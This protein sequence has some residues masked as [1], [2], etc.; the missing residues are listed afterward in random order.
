[1]GT[2]SP[3]TLA[4]SL[5]SD[6]PFPPL[7][8]FRGATSESANLASLLDCPCEGHESTEETEE[9]KWIEESEVDEMIYDAV[10]DFEELQDIYFDSDADFLPYGE[11]TDQ[12]GSDHDSD[13]DS[14]E[15][16][17]MLDR[18]RLFR[19]CKN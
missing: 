4:S 14:E 17:G 6:N 5:L 13:A 2:P 10:G 7:P 11:T 15:Y 9:G 12:Y 3:S 19:L 1:M 16:W 18:K 8:Y